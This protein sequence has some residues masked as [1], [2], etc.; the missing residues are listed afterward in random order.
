MTKLSIC[1]AVYN[2]TELVR[3]NLDELAACPT[4]NI[5]VLVSD[6]CSTEDIKGLVESYN[7]PRFRYARTPTN[8]GHD[9]NI[10]YGMQR[11]CSDYIMLMRSRDSVV[12]QAIPAILQAIQQ[13][14]NASYFLFSAFDEAGN[15]RL[16]L[17]D[18]EY[19][20]GPQTVWAQSNLLTHPSGSIYNRR[21]LRL[22]LYDA[23][24]RTYFTDSYGFVAHMLMRADAS[25]FG[26]FITSSTFA[27]VYANTLKAT[28]VAVNSTKNR[29]NVFS[30]EFVYERYI[31]EFDFTRFDLD[32]QMARDHMVGVVH[33]YY[34]LF[35]Y[36]LPIILKSESYARHYNCDI[37]D[38][39]AL[40]QIETLHKLTDYLA[41]GLCEEERAAIAQAEREEFLKARTLYPAMRAARKALA[42]CPPLDTAYR[43]VLKAISG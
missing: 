37:S 29:T 30:P 34:E 19:E 42:V 24:R 1:F 13:H 32:G 26:I 9:G 25:T 7:D 38:Y 10:V 11:C 12:P 2:Q 21:A 5:E 35:L 33:R 16:K 40:G 20:V 28:D 3:H 23:Y 22:D 31:C 15:E 17:P 14:P 39:D 6:D 27:W 8:L 4:K 41:K 18:K 43:A 36:H